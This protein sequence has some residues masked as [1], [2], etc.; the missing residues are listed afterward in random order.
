MKRLF[1][2]LLLVFFFVLLFGCDMHSGERPYDY[3]PAIWVSEK[4][5]M[6]FEI[7]EFEKN[8][9]RNRVYG[10]LIVDGQS[11]EIEVF[12]DYGS[13]VYFTYP[14]N[15][16]ATDRLTTGGDCKFSPDKL[17]VKIRE[18]DSLFNG[19]YKTITFIRYL[20]SQMIFDVLKD[21]PMESP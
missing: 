19:K 5:K 1:I 4:P 16:D 15:Q 6:W 11:I 9:Q 13:G 18:R 21:I 3:P 12:F 10:N 20:S 2:I 7:G 8:A 17:I 14:A